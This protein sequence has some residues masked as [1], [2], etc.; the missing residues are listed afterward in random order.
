MSMEWSETE[1]KLLI[2]FFAKHECL[3][4]KHHTDYNYNRKNKLLS[5]LVRDLN[6]ISSGKKFKVDIVSS[7]W[8]EL[9]NIY[10]QHKRQVRADIEC[11]SVS[12]TIIIISNFR[13]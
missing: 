13:R 6:K 12:Q 3:H 8:N 11:F 5:E 1:E 2:E 4:N 9:R 7:H 10:N